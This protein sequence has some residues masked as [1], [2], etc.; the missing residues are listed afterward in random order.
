[1]SE[2]SVPLGVAQPQNKPR[3]RA[4]I[5]MLASIMIVQWIFLFV[6]SM[7]ENYGRFIAAIHNQESNDPL[8]VCM[9]WGS[10]A[11]TFFMPLFP[12]YVAVVFLRRKRRAILYM[13]LLGALALGLGILLFPRL[14]STLSTPVL[15]LFYALGIVPYFAGVWLG[16]RNWSTFS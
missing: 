5:V 1:M 16:L 3:D 9:T 7:P 15:V 8:A 10:A 4:L 12:A 14:S 2:Q 13:G 11:L 6:D